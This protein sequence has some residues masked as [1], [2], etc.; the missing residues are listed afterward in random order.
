MSGPLTEAQEAK[1][2]VSVLEKVVRIKLVRVGEA[3]LLP[4][5]DV[6]DHPL[7]DREVGVG[8]LVIL[9]ADSLEGY[10]RIRRYKLNISIHNRYILYL[11]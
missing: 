4:G 2:V 8:N 5:L 7:G 11:S 3:Q 10:K 9:T 6:D 1:L